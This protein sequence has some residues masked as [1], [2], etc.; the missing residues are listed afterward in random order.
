M[1]TSRRQAI[2]LMTSAGGLAAAAPYISTGALQST[3]NHTEASTPYKMSKLIHGV[4][5]Y[6]ELWPAEDVDRDITEMKALGIN[7]IRIGEF[8]WSSMEPEEGKI[9]TRFFRDVMDKFHAAGIS[10]VFCTPTPT[11]PV[12]LTHGHPDRLFV[13]ADGERLIH[14][15][16]QHVS[17]EHPAVR[18][19]CFRIVEAIAK[20][21][22]NH[23]ALVAWQID[24]ELK[25][26]VAEDFSPGAIAAW[27]K[28]LK[29]RFGTIQRLNK[30]WGTHMWSTYYQSFEQVPAPFKTPF[31]H[32]ASLSTAYRMFNRESIAEFLDMQ[33]NIL[34]QHSSA[35]IT[36]NTNPMFSVNHERLFKNLDF[37][38]YDGY[39]TSEQW[40]ALVFRSD[41]YRAAKPGRPFWFME[42]SVAHNG[43]LGNH[44]TMHPPGFLAAE[45][46]LV[47]ALGGEACC[48]WL[49]R[50]QRTG[51]EIS[52]SAV[53]SS[54]YKP[55]IGYSQVQLVEE[56]RKKLEPLLLESKP[57]VPEIAVTW[58]DHARA[59]I[60][61]EPMDRDEEFPSTYQGVVEFWHQLVFDLGY[62][63]EVRF[64]GAAL[65]GLKLL[66]TPAMPYV[67]EEF[68]QRVIPFVKEGGIWLIGPGT[69]TRGREHTVP[70]TAGLGLLDAVAGVTT[71]Y[72]FPLTDTG[73]TGQV[74]AGPASGKALNFTGWC[75]AVKAAHSDTKVLGTLNTE[76]APGTAFLT[77]RVLGKGKVILLSAHPTGDEGRALLNEM[78]EGY[79]RELQVASP[80]EVS[81]GTV[82]CPRA[83]KQG[84]QLWVVI[85][86]DGQGGQVKLPRN[87]R[88]AVTGK[89]LGSSSLTLDPYGWRAISAVD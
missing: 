39:P 73:I 29:K 53:F 70:T 30:E 38:S 78:I 9:S 21:L 66:I 20:D 63:R 61:T 85:N 58:S 62:H 22:G 18:A 27:H 55:S 56:A 12:W 84:N 43:W 40:G 76:L 42:T 87:A 13:N 11:P 69:G 72:V 4:C 7:L 31:L 71:E 16:R 88:D 48:Y 32:S 10:V 46:V 54:W 52:H 6:P 8:T 64:E 5:Y 41:M 65:N 81:E 35:P 67:S 19:A 36:H 86:M 77:E 79:A 49:W 57:V 44:S 34:R 89:P 14:G 23:P 25:C 15:A 80:F 60:E 24:N 1:R 83:D 17:Y 75:A 45:T 68:L 3:G 50:Q 82:V 47:Y 2:K 59:M 51:A 33:C 37:A 26:H 74:K 28:W